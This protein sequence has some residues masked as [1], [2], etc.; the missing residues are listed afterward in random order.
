MNQLIT[1][2]IAAHSKLGRNHKYFTM[3]EDNHLFEGLIDN[4][5]SNDNNA[6][7]L[8]EEERIFNSVVNIDVLGYLIGGGINDDT[9]LE[10]KYENIVE[11]KISRERVILDDDHDRTNPSGM[12]PF[13][14]E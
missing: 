1:P 12:N 4:S 14:K 5:F 11:V 13:Y 7:K 9:P 6:A 10:K 2:F 8:D 3:V